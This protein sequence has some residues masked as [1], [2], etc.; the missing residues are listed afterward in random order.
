MQIARTWF[1]IQFLI[2]VLPFLSEVHAQSKVEQ[3][4]VV[5]SEILQR[6]VK[7]SVYHPPSYAATSSEQ[8][9]IMY[10]LHGYGGNEN[11][12]LKRCKLQ[13]LMDSLITHHAN[14]EFV[15]VMPDAGNSY[16]INDF[17]NNNKYEDFFVEEFMPYIRSKFN[18]D[19]TYLPIIC[20]LSMGGFGATILPVKHPDKFS[21]SIN[22]S[23]AVRTRDVFMHIN[24]YKY[25]EYFGDIYG[26]DLVGTE[27]ITNHWKENSPYYLIDS[28]LAQD[29]KLINWYIDCGMQDFLF[30]SNKALHELFLMY[31]ISHEYHMRVGGHEWA[32]WRQGLINAMLYLSQKN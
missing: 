13:A 32:Y 1:I 23:G 6:D 18:A 15:I 5:E 20:G 19:T 3:S 2:L 26:K 10:L 28:T 11:S 22:L 12:W 9:K 27:R 16:Y 30:Y 7:Y 24:Q 21:S 8:F 4:L 17:Q 14:L 31:D 29:L 25:N